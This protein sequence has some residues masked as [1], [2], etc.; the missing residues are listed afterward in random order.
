MIVSTQSPPFF[1][2]WCLLLQLAP[3]SS[4]LT[5]VY[6][7]RVVSLMGSVLSMLGMVLSIIFD[8][9]IFMHCI[10]IGLI[11][12]FGLG[13]LFITQVV[14]VTYWFDKKLA[15]ATGI[16]ECGSGIGV[17]VFAVIGGIFIDSYTWKGAML[18]LAGLISLCLVFSSLYYDPTNIG[19]YDSWKD[20]LA[21]K[22]FMRSLE[23]T[24]N[25][26]V[27]TNNRQFLLY[28]ISN[29]LLCLVYFTPIVVTSDR[30]S[31]SNMGTQADSTTIYICFGL[32]N[33]IGRILFG[34]IA[35]F[36]FIKTLWLYTI[37]TVLL[38]F[39][40]ILTVTTSSMLMMKIIYV[41]IGLFYGKFR[42]LKWSDK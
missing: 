25:F 8:K 9:S 5:T 17:A 39:C 37:C 6:G 20:F 36:N 3:F 34:W 21:L 19:R 35:T 28:T 15:L 32:S 13:L 26:T 1:F 38:G 27:L 10:T 18:I 2:F 24:V 4:G 12:G 14:V 11:N 33:G 40:V 30:I 42:R 29:F 16:A 23:E 41:G 31:R 22:P 7:C